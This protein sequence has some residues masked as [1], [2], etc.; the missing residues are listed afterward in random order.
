M[1][2]MTKKF[3]EAETF[4]ESAKELVK[5]AG[6]IACGFAAENL[7][8]TVIDATV[9]APVGFGAKIVYKF[10]KYLVKAVVLDAVAERSYETIDGIDEGVC[11]IAKAVKELKAQKA[12]S[13]EPE[14]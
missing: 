4:G 5:I 6:A 7:V 2:D 10:S 1:V 8:E 12:E 9:P 11:M 13:E 14:A 3:D